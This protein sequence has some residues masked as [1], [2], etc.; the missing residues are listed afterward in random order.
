MFFKIFQNF[1]VFLS[2]AINFN[3]RRKE[4]PKCVHC[5]C[6]KYKRNQVIKDNDERWHLKKNEKN[7]V[8]SY[9]SIVTN[10][11][12]SLIDVLKRKGPMARAKKAYSQNTHPVIIASSK[13][14]L[15]WHLLIF[16][17]LVT[18]TAH[19]SLCSGLVPLLFCPLT[20][21]CGN[22]FGNSAC[23]CALYPHQHYRHHLSSMLTIQLLVFACCLRVTRTNA[24]ILKG[25][26][27]K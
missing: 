7:I 8:I 14:F 18:T 9:E 2:S 13:W 3:N 4:K 23:V 25:Q 26:N 16:K 5:T 12:P 17:K 15:N 22:S 20:L 21:N 10:L 11:L 1:V 24:H 27:E 6:D 19:S